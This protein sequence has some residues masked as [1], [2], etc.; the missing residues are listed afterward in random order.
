MDFI[1]TVLAHKPVTAFTPLH[2]AAIIA[3]KVWYELGSRDIRDVVKV[4]RLVNNQDDISRI[5]YNE[6]RQ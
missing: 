2:M 5:R 3:E 6:A 4:A 1:V